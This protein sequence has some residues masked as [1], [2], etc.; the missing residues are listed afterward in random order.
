MKKTDP[1]AVLRILLAALACICVIAVIR[2]RELS[3]MI[4]EVPRVRALALALWAALGLSFVSMY[5]GYRAEREMRRENAEL[6]Y[7]LFTD[8]LTGVANRMSRDAF[9]R[10]YAG[11]PLSEDMG[12]ATLI[13]TNLKQINEHCGRDSG[14][15]AVR[16]FSEILQDA[17]DDRAVSGRSGSRLGSYAGQGGNFIARTG[18]SRFLV[19]FRDCTAEKLEAFRQ[20]VTLRTQERAAKGEQLLVFA[21][22]TALAGRDEAD[23]L[24][25]LAAISKTR[26]EEK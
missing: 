2:D 5:L 24:A 22:G 8:P 17:S 4:V 12:C 25:E 9:L 14:D 1:R 11:E 16:A 23:S 15:A 20:A 13:L 26:A 7:A 6:E 19:I 10:Q 18:G 3:R 21:F